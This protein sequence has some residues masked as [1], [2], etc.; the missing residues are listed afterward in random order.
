MNWNPATA[1]FQFKVKVNFSPRRR[2]VRIGPD[3]QASQLL[4]EIAL[5]LTKI[6]VLSQVNG[7]YDPLGLA[8]PFTMKA[9][10][11]RKAMWM[12]ENKSLG[13]DDPLPEEVRKVWINFFQELFS[14]EEVKVPR[15]VRPLECIDN[16][17]LIL[18]S[19][20][21]DTAFGAAAYVRWKRRDGLC[22]S[23]LLSAKSRV[24]PLKRVTICRLELNR[25]V[26][27]KRLRFFF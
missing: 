26:L 21:S 9:K 8:G 12:G 11:L 19:D 20:G 10:V 6:I 22:E 15:C 14:M 2:K 25:A 24:A 16:P 17:I 5:V 27:S 23:R 4:S 18:F 3:I 7:I 13:W 1:Q